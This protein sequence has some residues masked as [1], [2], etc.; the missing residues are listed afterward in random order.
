MSY[1]LIIFDFDGTLA[2]SFPFFLDTVDLLADTHGFR[3]IDRSQLDTLRGFDAMQIIRHVGLP[4]W[5]LPRLGAHYKSLMAE[6][7]GAIPLFDGVPGMLRRLAQAGMTLGIVTSNSYDNVAAVL[8]ADNM[9]L[10]SHWECGASLFGKAG[11]LRRLVARSGCARQAV[12]CVGDELRD[13]D[14]A[15]KAGLACGAVAWGYA[16][17]HALQARQPTML[18]ASIDEL[19]DRLAGPGA[20]REAGA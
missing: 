20:S 9:A 4:L 1:Q 11:K 7:A 19:I 17:A 10:I 3:R 18:F 13:I 5:K 15:R 14:A 8:G 2:D 6:R 12:L 16:H